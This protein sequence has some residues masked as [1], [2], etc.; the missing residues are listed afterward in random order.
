MDKVKST[1]AAITGA[2]KTAL[3]WSASLV[4]TMVK[5]IVF[6]P[7]AVLFLAVIAVALVA[8]VIVIGVRSVIGAVKKAGSWI[9]GLFSKKAP[10]EKATIIEN[11]IAI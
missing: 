6:V 5:A 1:F 3:V 9:R 10:V 7:L 11:D 4:T 8:Q 2:F